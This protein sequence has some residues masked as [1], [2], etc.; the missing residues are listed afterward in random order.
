MYCNLILNEKDEEQL[1][2]LLLGFSCAVPAIG[3]A[4]AGTARRARGHFYFE[5]HEQFLVLKG[6]NP[7]SARVGQTDYH[8]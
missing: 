6:E 1:S 2:G 3:A 4:N 7:R 8:Q 5:Q